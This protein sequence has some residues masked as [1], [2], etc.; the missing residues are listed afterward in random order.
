MRKFLSKTFWYLLLQEKIHRKNMFSIVTLGALISEDGVNIVSQK[1]KKL[2][3]FLTTRR[4]FLLFVIFEPEIISFKRNF[5]YHI[6]RTDFL[7]TNHHS[8]VIVHLLH[9]FLCKFISFI[10]NL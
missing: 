3:T 7:N 10:L 8:S 4:L 2:F 1:N 6:Y 9:G 5:K